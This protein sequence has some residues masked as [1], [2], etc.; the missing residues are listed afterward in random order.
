MG[1]LVICGIGPPG[2]DLSGL[3]FHDQ[4]PGGLCIVVLHGLCQL[5]LHNGL[6]VRVNGQIHVLS[7]NRFLVDLRGPRQDRAVHR[8][9]VL[10]TPVCSGQVFLHGQLQSH[11]SLYGLF[12]FIEGR[13]PHQI[14]GIRRRGIVPVGGVHEPDPRNVRRLDLLHH[15]FGQALCAG[16]Q[17]RLDLAAFHGLLQDG[18]YLFFVHALQH[19]GQFLCGFLRILDII[20]IPLGIPDGIVQIRHQ[21]IGLHF[22]GNHRG[23]AVQD[24]PASGLHGGVH[25]G[26][27]QLAGQHVFLTPDVSVCPH[28]EKNISSH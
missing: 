8:L 21:G 10:H 20:G 23:A 22:L 5:G 16:A 18:G 12:V 9:L 14:G 26:G 25:N 1:V 11:F 28:S 27:S 13:K 4:C 15:V 19:F 17:F 3:R 7:I 6:Q 24:L 2:Q